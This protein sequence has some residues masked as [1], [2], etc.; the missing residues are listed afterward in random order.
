MNFN[1]VC[2]DTLK[3]TLWYWCANY[4]LEVTCLKYRSQ[5]WSGN[6]KLEYIVV[7]YVLEFV[8]VIW[9][10][11]SY[12]MDIKEQQYI[13]VNHVFELTDFV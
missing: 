6:E 1:E 8:S 10:G 4:I 3:T 2:L 9:C 13:D 7:N 12:I 11:V 5:L